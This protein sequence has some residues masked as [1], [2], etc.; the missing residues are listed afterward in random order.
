M[1]LL[2]L[3]A[4]CRVLPSVLVGCWILLLPAYDLLGRPRSGAGNYESHRALYT[5]RI[6]AY[7]LL[8]IL[9]LPDEAQST[10]ALP[11]ARSNC[12]TIALDSFDKR[13]DDLAALLLVEG[14]N[15][16][17]ELRDIWLRGGQYPLLVR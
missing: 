2:P 6:H 14:D 16:L 9:L 11:K 15:L 17:A 13:R 12:Q 10:S 7:S 3:P 5:A 4:R 1:H 8:S